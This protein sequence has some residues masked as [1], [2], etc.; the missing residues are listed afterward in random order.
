M[1][2]HSGSDP[3]IDGGGALE[4]TLFAEDSIELLA[5][6]GIGEEFASR[7]AQVVLESDLYAPAQLG[8]YACHASRFFDFDRSRWVLPQ[9]RF[10]VIALHDLGQKGTSGPRFFEDEQWHVFDLGLLPGDDWVNEWEIA[11]ANGFVGPHFGVRSV[12]WPKLDNFDCRHDEFRRAVERVGKDLDLSSRPTVLLAC[13]WSNSDQLRET[14]SALGDRDYQV[15]VKF[16]PKSQDFTSNIWSAALTTAQRMVQEARSFAASVDEVRIA[17]DDADIAVLAAAS[18]VIV[19]N[20][21][22]VLYEGAMVGT[23]GVS[24]RDWLHP[25]GLLGDRRTAPS[26]DLPGVISCELG[27]LGAMIDVALDPRWAGSVRVGSSGFVMRSGVESAAARAVSAIEGSLHTA[28]E[29]GY[30][31]EQ[32]SLKLEADV[33]TPAG[34][35]RAAAVREEAARLELDRLEHLEQDKRALLAA[36]D[37][38]KNDQQRLET[39][40]EERQADW[41]AERATIAKESGLGLADD[42]SEQGGEVAILANRVAES[43]REANYLQHELAA[44]RGRLANQEASISWRLFQ[45]FKGKAI[46]LLGGKGSIG[47]RSAS[48]ALRVAHRIGASGKRESPVESIAQPSFL[49]F[50]LPTS[51]VPV[52][53]IVIPVHDGAGITERCLRGLLGSIGDLPYEVIVVDDCADAATKALLAS[54]GGLRVVVNETNLNFLRSV[55]RGAAEAR[56]RHIVLLNNDTEP[57]PGWLRA[58][59]DRADSRD[60]IGVVAAKLIYPDGSLQEAGGIVWRDGT[61]WNFGRGDGSSSEPQYSYVRSIDYGSAAA[62]LVRRTVWES[63]GGFD[64]RFAP[65]YWEDTDLCFAARAAGS[66]VVY[67]PAAVVVH[68][69]GQSMGTDTA[70]GGKHNQ[71]LNQPKFIE[72]WKAV[73]AAHPD[74]PH[75]HRAYLASNWRRGEVVLIVDHQ[76]PEPDKDA[77]SLRMFTVIENLVELG[78]RVVFA[79]DGGAMRE[80]YVSALTDLGVQVV[81]GSFPQHVAALAPDLQLVILSR[82]YVASRYLHQIR[83]HA[84]RATVAYDTVDLHFV[85]EE[86]RAREAGH[87]GTLVADAFRHLELA[88]ASASDVTIVVSDNEGKTIQDLSGAT[89]HVVPLANEVWSDVPGPEERSGVIFI[90]GFTH[91]PNIDA[92]IELATVVMPIVWQSLPGLPLTLVGGSAPAAVLKLAGA[93]V[94]VTGW[95]QDI[96]PLLAKARVMAAPLR[97]GAGVKGKVTQSLAAGLPVVTTP[98]GAE[99]LDAVDGEEILIADSPTE[100]AERIVELHRS[101]ELWASISAGG[102]DVAERSCSVAAQRRALEGLLE[103]LP[104]RGST[105]SASP[106]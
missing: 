83:E 37:H 45:R 85:R 3:V 77:G 27:S 106:S 33:S 23:P 5:I 8:I 59:V 100:I 65:G 48:K 99:G 12:G 103:G 74:R 28:L 13:S 50:D 11:R 36:V 73:L 91:H 47:F 18:D 69:E 94:E 70:S 41:E 10:S 4:V 19:S 75:A 88:M 6:R 68:R 7:G 97:F 71:V 26:I 87:S 80:P 35:L 43:V 17:N 34:S 104:G 61:A 86:G 57:Q 30:G 24:V 82:P 72:K 55:N 63:L 78:Y 40:L 25:Y 14:L 38:G 92:A 76:I 22:G 53:S 60:E 95:V 54:V 79:P 64:E 32:A 46:K 105:K 52:A 96:D 44:A 51:D 9:S 84:P 66:D 21:S 98:L 39:A 56:G 1:A 90:A 29:E 81:T 15:V 16:P 67:E 102:L 42:A 49:P 2:V 101:D 31:T 58:L 62:L 93:D 20:G 89:T